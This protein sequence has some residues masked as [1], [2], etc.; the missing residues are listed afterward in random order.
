[1]ALSPPNAS[2]AGLWARRAAARA[3][4]TSTVIQPIVIACIDDAANHEPRVC[5]RS[6]RHRPIMNAKPVTNVVSALNYWCIAR[7]V[8]LPHADLD[9]KFTDRITLIVPSDSGQE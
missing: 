1:M 9:Y 2:K 7:W 5:K 3:K 4:M 8:E 6:R